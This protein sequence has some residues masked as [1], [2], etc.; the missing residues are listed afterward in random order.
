MRIA[1]LSDIHGNLPALEAV[2]AKVRELDAGATYCLGDTVGYGPFPNECVQL[3]QQNCSVALKGNHE[4]G[5][6]GEAPLDDF[7][8]FGIEA[9][10]WSQKI[11][12]KE[13]WDY[14]RALPFTAFENGITLAHASPR[15]PNSWEYIMTIGAAQDNFEAFDTPLCFIGHTHVPVII[16]QDSSINEFRKGGR[17]IINVGSV[18]QPRDGHPEA[19]FGLYDTE[20]DAYSLI[21]VPYEIQ[22]TAQAI[23]DAGLPEF[24]AQRLFQGV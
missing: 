8:Q 1:I 5:M 21:R 9:I 7:N 15:D 18:G 2:L 16:G 23:H 3:V 10:L 11:V 14:L 6:M 12:T 24:L 22:K 19:A 4:C 17:F 13:N 20:L